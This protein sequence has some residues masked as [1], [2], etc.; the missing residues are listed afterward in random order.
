MAQDH[1]RL[2][3]STSPAFVGLSRRSVIIDRPASRLPSAPSRPP[4]PI[5]PPAG[6]NSLSSPLSLVGLCAASLLFLESRLCPGLRAL[7]K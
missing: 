7:A 3:L 4:E 5:P 6:D 1:G 2:M